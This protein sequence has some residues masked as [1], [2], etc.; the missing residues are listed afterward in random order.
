MS[1]AKLNEDVII[2]FGDIDP[3]DWRN[4]PDPE[5]ENEA[6]LEN[7]DQVPASQFVIQTLGF[8]PNEL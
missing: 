1:K 7:D 6:A 3:M 8:D 4:L 5:E 2:D